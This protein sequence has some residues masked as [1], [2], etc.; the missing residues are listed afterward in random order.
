MNAL[1]YEPGAA[2]VWCSTADGPRSAWVK[3]RSTSATTPTSSQVTPITLMRDITETPIALMM[4][5]NVIRIT[6][7]RTALVAPSLEASDGSEPTSWKPDHS[8]GMTTCSAIAA[9]DTV[10]ICAIS[11]VQP[12]N[13]PTVGVE[14]RRDHW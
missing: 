7:S 9:A 2:P 13:Q 5:V 3:S 6:P 1:K 14:S 4:V 8:V 11:I 12:A 10:T